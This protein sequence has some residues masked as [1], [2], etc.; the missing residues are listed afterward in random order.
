MIESVKKSKRLILM[1]GIPGSGKSTLLANHEAALSPKHSIISRDAIR[2]SLLKE[3][4][5]YFSKEKEVWREY[6]SQ[7]KKSLEENDDTVLDATHLNE[8]SRGKILRALG[9]SLKDVAVIAVVVNPGLETAIAQNNTREGRSFVPV[10]EIKKM[11]SSFT[12]PS[13][14]EGFDKIYYVIKGETSTHF[15]E[16][17]DEYEL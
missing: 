6:V 13:F 17:V 14:A 8:A 15:L 10:S 1:V 16:M 2:F 12:R 9:T 7:A 11:Y 5:E 4:E 3:G